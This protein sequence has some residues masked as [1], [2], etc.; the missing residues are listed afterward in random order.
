MDGQ[1]HQELLRVRVTDQ[2][3]DRSANL[4]R[5]SGFYLNR[6]VAHRGIYSGGLPRTI[7]DFHSRAIEGDA[8]CRCS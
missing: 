6:D 7:V 4:F 3:E 8:V 1:E 2:I 5:Y